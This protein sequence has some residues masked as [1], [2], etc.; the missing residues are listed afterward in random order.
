MAKDVYLRNRLQLFV[1]SVFTFFGASPAPVRVETGNTDSDG[2][3]ICGDSAFN[4]CEAWTRTVIA[5]E[6]HKETSLLDY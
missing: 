3:A 6:L 1:A 5:T 2:E 4:D